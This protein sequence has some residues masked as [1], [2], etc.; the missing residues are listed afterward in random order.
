MAR[1]T[2]EFG[3]ALLASETPTGRV[4][5][6]RAVRNFFRDQRWLLYQS[7]NPLRRVM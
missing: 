4:V 7:G 2:Q 5:I 6:P 1:C 3:N